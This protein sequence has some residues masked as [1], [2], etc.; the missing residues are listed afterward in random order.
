MPLIRTDLLDPTTPHAQAHQIYGGLDACLTLEIF[1]KMSREHNYLPEVYSFTR[2]LQAPALEMMLRGFLVDESERRKGM[3]LLNAIMAQ[4][5]SALQRM[6]G[7]VWGKNLNPRS[8][9]QLQEFFYKYMHLPEQWISQKG[10]KKLSMNR[11]VLEKLDVYLLARPIIACILGIRDLAKELETLES[12]IDPDGRMRTSYNIV[13]T[14]TGR[15]SSS[16]S[17][18]GTGL[19]AQNIKRKLRKIFIADKGWKLCGIDLE[20]AESRE[21]GWLCGIL[22][23]EWSYLDACL[24]GDLH[25]LTCRLIWPNLAW[26]GDIK[27]DKKI[28][29][30]IFYREFSY[31]DMSKRGGHG[32]LTS[33]HEVLTRTGWVPIT[34]KP[35]EILCWSSFSSYFAPVTHWT[36]FS[37]TGDL[38]KFEGNSISLY[39]TADHRIPY[40]SD[41]RTPGIK[42]KPAWQGPGAYMPLGS[43]YVGGNEVVPARLV[44]AFMADGYQKSVNRME[45]H[46]HKFRKKTRLIELCKAFGYEYRIDEDNSKI[47]ITGA[48]PKNPGAFMF[49]WTSECLK[50]FLDEYKYWDGHKSETAVALFSTKRENLEWIQTLGRICGIGGA[51][52]K[53]NIS[54][55]G[56]TVHKLQQ[57]NRQYATGK[58]MTFAGIPVTEQR[59][60]CP[61]VSTSFFYVRHNGK[62]SVTGNSNYYGTPFTMARHLKVPTKLMEDFQAKYFTAF[63]G[64][65]KYHRWIAQQLQTTRSLT[66]VFG[67]ERTFFGRPNDDTTLREAIAFLPQSATGDR[68]NLALWRIWHNMKNVRLAAQVHDAVYFQYHESENEAQVI[69]QALSY[70]DVPIADAKSGRS[71]TIPGEA[72]VGWNWGEVEYSKDGTVK[73]NPDGLIKWKGE[74]KRSRTSIFDKIQ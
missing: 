68:L 24:S 53:P 45:F 63:P 41:Q 6:A 56:S 25:T 52:Q 13:G 5:N 18:T 16:Q 72:K 15:W 3:D 54:G 47:F 29:E 71:Y 64:I 66:T 50:N 46:F 62:I 35:K 34:N 10:V 23:G 33:D 55:F 44:A 32:C 60:L 43:N 36:D 70:I 8:T 28:A 11:E 59:V 27:K 12:E 69:A 21:V 48:L 51:F 74:D 31:R 26:T 2:A 67:R 20:Q 7:A 4:Y 73:S 14:E 1:Q 57:N 49:N 40:C 65:P 39:T 9:L 37:Y 38:Y 42:V 61:T 30:T 22:F 17:S 58:S 19:N